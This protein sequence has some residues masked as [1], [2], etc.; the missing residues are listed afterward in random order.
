MNDEQLAASSLIAAGLRALRAA[1]RALRTADAALAARP[2]NASNA[3]WFVRMF[4][5]PRRAAAVRADELFW[6]SLDGARDQHAVCDE[7]LST[8]FRDF[9][10]Y[11]AVMQLQGE[12]G[13]AGYDGIR[14]SLHRNVTAG[15]EA[16]ASLQLRPVVAR[17]RLSENRMLSAIQ[18]LATT[19]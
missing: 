10:R 12:L 9:A 19:E 8:L 6:T 18:S 15:D 5:M 2:T 16:Q 14:E 7:A 17:M 1:S 4:V 3:R 11:E 13:A